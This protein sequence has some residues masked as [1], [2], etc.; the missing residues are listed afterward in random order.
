MVLK[1]FISLIGWL[2]DWLIDCFANTMHSIKSTLCSTQCGRVEID[3]LLIADIYKY[4]WISNKVYKDLSATLLPSV[5]D[6]Y[7]MSSGLS[8]GQYT[9]I[10]VSDRVNQD[11][12]AT[13]YIG[14]S[15]SNPG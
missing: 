7:P 10:L 13:L 2:I 3:G 1:N 14:V 6:S 9:G 15:V 8:H 11:L 5:S 4:T 12:Q